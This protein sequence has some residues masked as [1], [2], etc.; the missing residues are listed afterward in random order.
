MNIGSPSNHATLLINELEFVENSLIFGNDDLGLALSDM[1]S[2]EH[3]DLLFDNACTAPVLR[4][5][6]D[7]ETVG[8]KVMMQGQCHRDVHHSSK[9]SPTD[10]HSTPMEQ[11]PTAKLRPSTTTTTC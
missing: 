8:N 5:K 9:D 3:D 10:S 4:S 1:R 2:Q 11:P 6:D 7:C